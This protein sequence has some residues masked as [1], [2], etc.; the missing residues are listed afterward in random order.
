VAADYDGDG[1]TDLAVFR[2]SNG[3][4][5]LRF[6]TSNFSYAGYAA[7]PWGLSADQPVAGDFD[8]DGRADIAVWR[9]SNG[10]WYF[11]FSASGYSLSGWKSVQWGLP[12]D[13]PLGPK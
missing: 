6:S 4:W 11:L 7:Y 3:T 10:T 13:K 5:Y 2:P 1:K 8:G 9:P 12:G